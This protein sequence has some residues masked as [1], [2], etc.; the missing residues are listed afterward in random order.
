M[1]LEQIGIRIDEEDLMIYLAW[2]MIEVVF[3]M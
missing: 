1:N 2:M 3:L